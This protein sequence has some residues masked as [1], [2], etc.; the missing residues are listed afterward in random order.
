MTRSIA[1]I[2]GASAL[3]GFS[4]GSVHSARLAAW[5]LA[6]FPLLLLTTCA[7][8]ALAYVAFAAVIARRL[9]PRDV[10]RAAL[11]TFA[12]LSVL[13]AS[14]AP[15]CWF[16]ATTISRPTPDSLGEYPLFLGLNVAFIAVCGAVALARQ[17]LRLERE[18][19][20][21]RGRAAAVLAAWLLVSLFAGGQCAWFMRPF[22]GVSTI[23]VEEFMDGTKPDYR[24]ATSFYEAVWQL[25]APPPLPKDYARPRRGR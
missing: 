6:K 3:Y 21:G 7:I 19:R 15:V 24:G 10:M 2:A 1:T 23:E 5:D 11:Q 13:L 9:A 20:L 8:C 16:L 17:T 12:D 18:H 22:F 25:A 4:V 14:L